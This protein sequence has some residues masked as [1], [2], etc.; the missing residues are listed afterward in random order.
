M[1]RE[2]ARQA[3][4]NWRPGLAEPNGP[5]IYAALAEVAVDPELAR[6]FERHREF[7]Q[8]ASHALR[9]IPVP[10]DLAEQILARAK[11]VP[12][13][14]PPVRAPRPRWLALTAAAAALVLGI[15]MLS[16]WWNAPARDT[17]FDTFRRRMVRA[18][19]REYR[20][21]IVTNDLTAI[22]AYLAGH[23]APANFELPPALAQL[24]PMGGGLLSWR[25][26]NASMVCLRRAAPAE[27]L[28]LFIIP[29]AELGG[30]AP[31]SLDLRPIN[32]LATASWSQGGNTYV[33][34]SGAGL[35]AL[36]ALLVRDRAESGGAAHRHRAV[37]LTARTPAPAPRSGSCAASA[38]HSP[39]AHSVALSSGARPNP[40]WPAG[41]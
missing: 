9:E 31:E 29:Q 21:D 11:T 24:P 17:D 32:R 5:E 3:L 19:L 26:G 10:A 37:T 16:W 13:P 40:A 18:A 38:I 34:A 35:D 23:Q 39:H 28:F 27:T 22:R 15:G 14:A 30:A 41:W 12:I 20:M 25:H 33:L 36:R 2:A 6:W 8:R 1:K 4:M 7:Q